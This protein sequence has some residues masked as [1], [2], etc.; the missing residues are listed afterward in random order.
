MRAL[1]IVF[2]IIAFLAATFCWMVVFQHGFSWQAFT[3]GAREELRVL[4]SLVTG[5][6]RP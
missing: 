1:P 2:W 6:S 3:S 4:V 5:G